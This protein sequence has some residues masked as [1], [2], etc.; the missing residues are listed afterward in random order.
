M[1]A[2]R[3]VGRVGGLAVAL[4]VGVAVFAGQGAAAADTG[5]PD[6][7]GS[8]AGTTQPGPGAD[9]QAPNAQKPNRPR[10]PRLSDLVDRGDFG[11]RRAPT[12]G[13]DPTSVPASRVTSRLSEV[14]GAVTDA[15]SDPG[16]PSSAVAAT[17]VVVR[18]PVR[19]DDGA[20]PATGTAK[21]V[22]SAPPPAAAA[23][24]GA[25][26][27][28]ASPPSDTPA[29]WALLAA[30]RREIGTDRITYNPTIGISDL[31]ITG[32]NPAAAEGP[33]VSSRNLPLT[34]TVVS[35]PSKQGKVT[36]DKTTGGFSYLP[37]SSGTNPDG[38]QQ[39][40]TSEEFKVLVAET[41]PLVAALE[42]IPVAGDLVAPILVRI[43]QVPILSDVLAPVIGYAVIVPI[44]VNDAQL[45]EQSESP[46][47]FTTT[48]VSF[49]GTPISVNYFPAL[50]PEQGG[51]APTILNGPSLATAGY[52]DPTQ[53]TTVF[54][55]V[56]GLE[57][58]RAAGYNVV[59]W[60]PRGEFASGG[61]LQL[62]SP[63]Y[64][65]KDVSAI[66]T[67]VEGQP[68]TAFE[69]ATDDPLIG[70]V[71]GSYGGGIQLTSAGTDDRI[72]VIAPGIA[73]NSLS[74][75]LYPN[76]AFKTSF[77][78]LL[79]LSLV[80][81]DSRINR[82]IYSGIFTGATL[83]FLTRGQQDFLDA[84]SP[85]QVTDQ[86]KVPTLLL[87]GTVD[88]LFTLQQA[89]DN[90]EQIQAANPGV[91]VKMIW[92]CGGHGQCLD[93]VDQDA[94][95]AFL[96]QQ[97]IDWMDLYLKGTGSPEDIPDFQWVDQD[98]KLWSS[99]YLP[100][101]GSDLYKDSEPITAS[102]S[103]GVL[104]IVPVLGGS[105]PQTQ[106]KFPVSLALGAKSDHAIDVEIVNPRAAEPAGD[107]Y[108]VGAPEIT[109]EYSGVGTSRV[110]YAQLV[111]NQ[112]G[113][114]LGN[115]V[116]PI[117]VTLDGKTHTQTISMEN[118]A[119]TMEP[120]DS[121]TLQIVGSATPYENFTSYGVINVSKVDISLPTANPDNVTFEQSFESDTPAVGSGGLLGI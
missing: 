49:D 29:S 99:R 70:M 9:T 31:V 56:P 41:T 51:V 82:E 113:R 59:T 25:G 104:A 35:E 80:V 50:G 67:W 15:V 44:T 73:W 38:S 90:A 88:D 60:D 45:A 97:T 66:I 20:S 46:I 42:K 57:P 76:D 3:F 77:A 75:A 24:S 10:L 94:Q 18:K 43:H 111:D 12:A 118:I 27:A 21:T 6:T 4:G 83:G 89:I 91:P 52:I 93:P 101:T 26:T 109:L 47:A 65:A 107:V 92:Y 71:G 34:F 115:V 22:L 14:V 61:I 79:L 68:G 81:T 54:G 48:V 16:R 102:H 13:T 58:L 116:T 11:A 32:T 74:T 103:G 86:I 1:A 40:A 117:P 64:E 23:D 28:P 2:A 36:V 5:T 17:R 63:D 30:S 96:T 78:S 85:Y 100:M 119:Y 62:D 55:L 98:G 110:V 112:T 120:G 72:D 19:K 84:A 105:G 114:V 39:F 53:A 121:L 8:P 95:T 87:Q 37:Y 69:G 106:A 33:P 7:N 108:V